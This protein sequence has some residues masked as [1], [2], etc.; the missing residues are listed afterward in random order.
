MGSRSWTAPSRPRVSPPWPKLRVPAVRRDRLL[1]ALEPLV[2]EA[3]LPLALLS[4]PA[5]F[6]KTTL[7][8]QLC[9]ELTD[10]G[11][12]HVAWVALETSGKLAGSVWQTI[13]SAL[14]ASSPEAAKSLA[15]LQRPRRMPDDAFLG[16]FLEHAALLPNPTI[17]VIDDVQ[18]LANPVT[19]AQLGVLCRWLPDPLRLVI[20][21]RH[22]PAFSLHEVRLAGNLV[23]LRA[24]ELAFSAD[25]T[26]EVL[27]D[28]PIDDSDVSAVE[29]LTE[30]WPAGVQL[31]RSMLRR[32]GDGDRLAALFETQ[33]VVLADYLFQ[34]LFT[35]TSPDDQGILLR[36][37]VVDQFNDDL[38]VELTGRPDAGEA[39]T[40]M[41]DLAPL[42][43]RFDGP[44]GHHVWY[45]YH[46]LL[47]SHLSA[48]LARRD[49]DLLR[50][51]H[52]RAAM[53]FG[54]NGDSLAAIKHALESADADLVDDCLRRFGPGLLLD[55]DSEQL[56]HDAA[57]HYQVSTRWMAV[58]T[59]CAAVQHGDVSAAQRWLAASSDSR[60]PGLR[61]LRSA[62]ALRVD[63]L[64]GQKVDLPRPPVIDA[65]TPED[66]LG[67]LVTTN[68]GLAL[69]GMDRS[70]AEDGDLHRAVSLAAVLGR[71]AAELQGRTLLAAAAMGRGDYLEAAQR[72]EHTVAR[73]T[74]LGS[75]DDPVLG[76]VEVIMGWTRFQQLDEIAAAQCLRRARSTLTGSAAPE[77]DRAARSQA[78]LL[79]LMLRD[80]TDGQ[81][82]EASDEWRRLPD[83]ALPGSLLV[84]ACLASVRRALRTGR[85]D[86]ARRTIE[87]AS[88]TLGPGD[89][90]TLRAMVLSA[91][92][93]DGAARR[94]LR[95]VV[96]ER[97]GC[98]SAASV[99]QALMLEATHSLRDHH[100][101]QAFKDIQRGLQICAVTGGYR[102]VATAAPELLA[103]MAE[104][105]D[106]LEQYGELIGRVM[107]YTRFP[108]VTDQVS[109]LTERELDV[110]RELPTL[111]H[112][113]EI[114]ANLMVS[115]NTVKTHIRGIYRK[116]GVGSRGEAVRIARRCGL[117]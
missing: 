23:E 95:S 116:L 56:R 13:L 19:I 24:H 62:V 35:A 20:S 70:P 17:L 32:R 47:R 97:A 11:R 113:D 55:G 68:R 51:S 53:W 57:G 60:D 117:L 34:E 54:R 108:V 12:G 33:A 28:L 59:A 25:E 21:T 115:P 72:T 46:P 43:N 98:R 76:Y 104:Q 30:G 3:G 50:A 7:L 42:L 90:N 107:D 106:R 92:N 111:Y 81:P 80:S 105:A 110:L 8:S 78:D 2:D 93:R 69:L 9:Q 74:D 10:S 103:Y 5:G 100:P 63:R 61:V 86:L 64:I 73:A 88:E 1:T 91:Q 114:A 40:K 66:D 36:T 83:A 45:R 31:A 14:G 16:R 96:E 15:M 101:Y 79:D 4:A 38:A 6:G 65:P 112:V 71:P 26:A 109:L 18:V 27:R 75:P 48:E 49:R 39:I 29:R 87:Y 99:V 67:L 37:S 77:V 44:S 52:R 82:P 94:L 84:Y 58:L 102:E 22:D 89:V 85:R 41:T